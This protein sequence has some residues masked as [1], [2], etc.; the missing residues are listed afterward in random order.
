[1]GRDEFKI[2]LF[3]RPNEELLVAQM[4]KCLSAG[5]PGLIPGS[6]RSSGE[7]N[8]NSLQH[9]CLEN[10]HGLRSLVGYSSWGHKELDTIEG[11]HFTSMK[12]SRTL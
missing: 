5:D 8:G 1:M 2:F 7:G 11:L 6:G 3:C 10:F 9:S 4:V 12:S